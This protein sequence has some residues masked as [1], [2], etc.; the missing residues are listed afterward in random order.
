MLGANTFNAKVARDAEDAKKTETHGSG[1][2]AVCV[3][4]VK[5]YSSYLG[6]NIHQQKKSAECGLF[7][8]RDSY[9]CLAFANF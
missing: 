5:N 2:C 7:V 4:C 9:V 6:V 3:S 8:D 1:S